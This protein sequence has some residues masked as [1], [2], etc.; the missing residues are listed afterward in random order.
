MF[1]NSFVLGDAFELIQKLP[2]E[3][4]D[5]ILT[6]PPYGID[7]QS[8][9]REVNPQWEKLIGDKNLSWLPKFFEQSFRV[10]KY[11][12]HFYCFCRW[13]VWGAFYNVAKQYFNVK[14]MIVWVK[15]NHGSGDLK[16]AYAPK[17]ELIL[18]AHKGRRTFTGLRHPDVFNVDNIPSLQRLHPTQKPA[19]LLQHFILNSTH[20]GEY[21]LDPFAGCGTTL[22][23]A[24]ELGRI[25][26]G[27]EIDKQYWEKGKCLL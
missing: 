16:G 3:S 1:E 8:N 19:L 12:R 2:G 22:Q 10:L 9:R 7:Y 24:K 5:L 23:A 14:N 4:I 25:Y 20:K 11:D 6:D 15:N 26:T 17:H 18:F 13:D 27:F 21:V